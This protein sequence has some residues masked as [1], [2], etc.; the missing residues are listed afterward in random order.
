MPVVGG[1]E[2]QVIRFDH[3]GNA[4]TNLDQDTVRG[5]AEN[6]LW[7]TCRGHDFKLQEYYD[8]GGGSGSAIINSDGLLEL[9]LFRGNARDALSLRMGDAVFLRIGS[10]VEIG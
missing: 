8:Q 7:I 10:S 3:F 4:I 5:F 2:G 1:L 6:L 9:C